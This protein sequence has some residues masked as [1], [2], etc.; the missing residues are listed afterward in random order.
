MT[1]IEDIISWKKVPKLI[2]TYYKIF[3]MSLENNLISKSDGERR[4]KKDLADFDSGAKNY[5]IMQFLKAD[6]EDL[7]QEIANILNI[8]INEIDLDESYLEDMLDSF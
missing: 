1:T 5:I 3:F 8:D 2:S 7:A 6:K 4:V